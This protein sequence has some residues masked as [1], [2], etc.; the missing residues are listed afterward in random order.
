MVVQYFSLPEPRLNNTGVFEIHLVKIGQSGSASDDLT[1]KHENK[2]FNMTLKNSQLI[3]ISSDGTFIL[4][5]YH[6]TPVRL[7]TSFFN[8]FTYFVF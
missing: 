4:V 3:E 6:G 1:G 7:Y 2:M 5:H 8:F